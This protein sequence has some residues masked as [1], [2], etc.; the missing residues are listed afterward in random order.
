MV[1]IVRKDNFSN[2]KSEHLS[3]IYIVDVILALH[4]D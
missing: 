1:L 3:R 2:V 4:V